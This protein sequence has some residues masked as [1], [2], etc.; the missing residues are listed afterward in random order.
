MGGQQRCGFD[1][2]ILAQV[3]G[4]IML[5]FSVI[6]VTFIGGYVRSRNTNVI[7]RGASILLIIAAVVLAVTSL[8]GFSRQRNSYP[9]GMTIA[10]VPVGGLNPAE[11]SQRL[12]EVYTTPIEA[13]YAGSDI[14]IDPE[15][16]GFNLDI[17]SMMAA[18]DLVRTGGPFWSGFWD[19][20]WNRQ[21]A[22][23]TVPLRATIE[24]QRLRAYL[25]NEIAPR[26]DQPPAPPQ[27][28]P[29]G[30]G[31]TAGTPGQV[32]DV[33]RAVVLIEDALRSPTNRTVSL[34]YNQNA[35]ARPTMEN[36]RLL[37][38]QYIKATEFD[39]LIGLFL[40]DLQTG[41][42]IHFALD[43]GQSV[44][45]EPDI[46]FTASSTIKIPILV[47][48][49]IKN[50]DAPVSDNV[51]AIIVN[52]IKKS[53]NPPS[54]AL[55]AQL[56]PNFGPL[57]VSDYMKSVGLENTFLAGFFAPGSPLLQRFNT[58]ANSR[59][60]INTDPDPYNQTT[61]A[62]MGM[63]LVDVYQCAQTGGGALVAAFPDKMNQ[64]ACQQILDYLATD[65]IGVLIEA[66][67][68]EG[69]VVAHKHGWVVDVTTGYM[70]NVSDAGIVYTPGGNFVLSIYAYHPVQV[71]FDEANAMFANLA[72]VVYNFYNLPTQ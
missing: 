68:P 41:Q 26:Y 45:V 37:L 48:Y 20:L 29:D 25:Q 27:P 24:E 69:T 56:D 49:F 15:L 57:V 28:R 39:G 60:D 30:L 19:Y 14:Q 44:P 10:G 3:P 33:E 62:D 46:A 43:Q 31:F 6:F 32:L 63:L 54:D 66:G 8:V 2:T 42:E 22:A 7:L 23:V 50:G 1:K 67:V 53:E 71:V 59:L 58:P 72:Q 4:V 61:P 18:A 36:L 34:S 12:L 47:S 21:A 13:Q 17:D 65:K 35:V 51:N 70:K 40:T 52:M 38:E 11:A 55:M 64:K 9:P 16:V 5:Y